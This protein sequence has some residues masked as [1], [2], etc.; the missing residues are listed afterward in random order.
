VELVEQRKAKASA[1][2][3]NM[4]VAR[5]KLLVVRLSWD[6]RHKASVEVGGE[7]PE[8]LESSYESLSTGFQ[9][10]RALGLNT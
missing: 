4:V 3:W 7:G 1:K 6:P 8:G 2:L 9:V 10:N 5:A